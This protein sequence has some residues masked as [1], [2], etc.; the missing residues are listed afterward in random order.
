LLGDA[1]D[2]IEIDS[3]PGNPHGIPA[4]AHAVLTVELVDEPGRPTRAALERVLTFLT[5]QLPVDTNGGASG[6]L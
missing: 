2:G 1:F 6:A 3:S 4:N 5:R